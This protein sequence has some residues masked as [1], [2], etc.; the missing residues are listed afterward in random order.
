MGKNLSRETTYIWISNSF[1]TTYTF[2][3]IFK[4]KIHFRETNVRIWSD[5]EYWARKEGISFLFDFWRPGM[6]VWGI[7][8]VFKTQVIGSPL[9]E[10]INMKHKITTAQESMTIDE[11]MVMQRFMAKDRVGKGEPF[12]AWKFFV[13]KPFWNLGQGVSAIGRDTG[14]TTNC[15]NG[16]STTAGEYSRA[17]TRSWLFCITWV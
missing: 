5:W 15:T 1:L 3:T 17:G 12:L 6:Y 8:Q 10:L 14:A 16:D 2:C 13:H 4:A 7:W 11:I 9:A